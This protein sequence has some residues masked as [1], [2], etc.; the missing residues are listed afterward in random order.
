M[1]N[2]IGKFFLGA[3]LYRNDSSTLEL[4]EKDGISLKVLEWNKKGF[5]IIFLL[6]YVLAV[7]LLFSA[8]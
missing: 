4:C 1:E 3:L 2:K 7:L 6:L 8:S 5:S